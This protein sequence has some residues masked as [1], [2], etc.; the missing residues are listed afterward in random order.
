M[1]RTTYGKNTY[2]KI[3]TS[4]FTKGE[5]RKYCEYQRRDM[6]SGVHE[7]GT[8][9]ANLSEDMAILYSA[10]AR[11]QPVCLPDHYQSGIH[12]LLSKAYTSTG[13]PSKS[14]LGLKF[15]EPVLR[16]LASAKQICMVGSEYIIGQG[17]YAN[18]CY[19]KYQVRGTYGQFDFFVIP[20]QS[21]MPEKERLG[22]S[23]IITKLR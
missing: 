14:V 17:G 22:F 2:A 8:P 16:I 3:F 13:R 1:L 9:E 18:L 12:W 7:P 4:Q 10:I 15:S 19:P 23:Q 11:F 20:W 21:G 6:N 5:I